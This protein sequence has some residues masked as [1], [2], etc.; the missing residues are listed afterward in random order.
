MG[1]F[2]FVSRRVL[3]VV[4][5]LLVIVAVVFALLHLAPGDPAR[6]VAGLRASDEELAE[7]RADL[8]IDRP[9]PV[10]YARYVGDVARGDLGYSYKSREPVTAMLGDRLP[11]SAWLLGFGLAL[12]VLIAV[13]L[14]V[15]ASRRPGGATDHLVR[16]SC[17]LGIALPSFWL[18]SMLLLAFAVRA[19]WFPAGGFGDSIGDRLHHVALPAITLALG[20]APILIRSLRAGILSTLERD[21][22]ATARS[23]G[24][25]ERQVLRHAVLRNAAPSAVTLLALEAGYLLFGAVVIETTFAY[26][27][28]GEGLVQAARG[29][30]LPAIQ[31]YTLLFAVTVVVVNLLADVATVILDPRVEVDT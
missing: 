9:L 26:P 22:I 17:Q 6:N 14:S 8:G 1:R 29:R 11:A 3:H 7:V 12:S 30:D 2:R 23:I 25:S 20:G 5:M 24:L 27:G 31:G 21:H 28:V 16:L 19:G 10:Q 13:P 18:G 15:S 4:P